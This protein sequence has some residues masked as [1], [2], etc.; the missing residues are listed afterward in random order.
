MMTVWN[1]A[2]GRLRFSLSLSLFPCA[3]DPSIS[4]CFPF[5]LG[6]DPGE[7][8]PFQVNPIKLIPLKKRKK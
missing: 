5:K 4:I 6:T 1:R 3:S 8:G 7:H 2:T